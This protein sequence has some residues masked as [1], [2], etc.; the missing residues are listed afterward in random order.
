MNLKELKLF[1]KHLHMHIFFK[2]HI[3]INEILGSIITEFNNDWKFS[4]EVSTCNKNNERINIKRI[5][6]IENSY[7]AGFILLTS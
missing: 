7:F 6:D 1:A 5:Y 3:V 2:E 4:L